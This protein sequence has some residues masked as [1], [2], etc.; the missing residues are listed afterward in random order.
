MPLA[1]SFEIQSFVFLMYILSILDYSGLTT[2]IYVVN[3][4]PNNLNDIF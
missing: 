2:D 1:N 4:I 3:D